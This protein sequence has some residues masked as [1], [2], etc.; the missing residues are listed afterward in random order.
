MARFSHKNSRRRKSSYRR[1]SSRAQAGVLRRGGGY[2]L[3]F[4]QQPVGGLAPIAAYNDYVFDG[5]KRSK[6]SVKRREAKKLSRR[7]KH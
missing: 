4:T 7:K 2:Y 6:K 5:G 3:D 1:K